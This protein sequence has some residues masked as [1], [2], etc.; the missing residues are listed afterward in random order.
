MTDGASNQAPG[1][2]AGVQ[3]DPRQAADGGFGADGTSQ[4]KD[5]KVGGEEDEEQE[6]ILVQ[7]LW[8]EYED[9]RKFDENYRKQ[10]AIDRRYAA[11]TSDL[12]WAVTTNLIGAFIDI[13]TALLYARD[14]EVSCRKA[15]QV[16]NSNTAQMDSFAKTLEIVITQLWLRGKLKKAAK[17]D[18]RSV[19]STAEGWL[20]CTIISEKKPRPEIETAL[21]DAQET[22]ARLQAQKELLEDPDTSSSEET[23]AL[24]EEKNLLIATLEEKL[25]LAVN[26]MFVIDFLQTQDVQVSTDVSS[27][28][29]HLDADWNSNELYLSKED[30]L[31][32]FPRLEPD[33]LKSAKYYY[34]RAPKEL[35]TRDIDNVLP[36]GMLTAETAQAFTTNQSDPTANAK[37]FLRVVEVWDRRD[38]H[39]RT[40]IDGVT[41]W[42][43]PP[44]PPPYP[45]QRFYPYFYLAFYEVD[46]ARHAQS[47]A[48]RL[49][50][51]QDEYSSVRSNFRITRQRAIPAT[52]F[53]ATGIDEGEARKLQ[54]AKEQEYVAIR[55]TD[56]QT[57][58]SNLFAAKPVSSI[59]P[60]LYDPTYILNDMERI[61]GVQE[62]L[63]SAIASTGNPITATEA[64]IQ[65]SGT[66]ARTNSDR[67]ALEVMLTDLAVY[68]AEQALQCLTL[69]DVQRMAGPKA[70]WPGPSEDGKPGMSI[71]DLF[72]MVEIDI[73]AGS[74]GKPKA[75]TDQQAWAT[76]LP[77]IRELLGQI[78][79]ALATGN[80][81]MA[82]SL[83][84]LI[85]ETMR[86]LGDDSD[87]MRF[88]PLQPPPGTPGAGAP[89]PPV[90]ENINVS[91]KGM[92]DPATSA[93]LV[94]PALRRDALSAPPP[95]APGG[96]GPIPPPGG[97]PIGPPGVAPP[98]GPQPMPNMPVP[99][100][101]QTPI[102]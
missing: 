24:I 19:L 23:D 44:Y 59:D 33:D 84:E 55:P 20:K 21:N 88:I 12:S 45:T 99:G 92:I 6:E 9:A 96:P 86:R 5:G 10:V 79:Q 72:T 35:T 29:D 13:L 42:A 95:V 71:E 74:T 32:R 90:P 39:I 47:L 82:N 77:L 11:G 69:R 43:N 66:A 87:P 36:Q 14:P 91:I 76:I 34:Q 68:T 25:E 7:R 80:Q 51:L 38:M 58:L 17:K 94:A 22:L 85:K 41:K 52:M 60:R 65:Q 61:S 98:G 57:P 53:N 54:E 63:Q 78:E 18:V 27:I 30:V 102:P 97:P 100:P 26:K 62:A 73:K 49:Y 75:P 70:F 40:L 4:V 2:T 15:Q 3:D 93:A 101:H 8:R 46:G 64:N 81:P 31:A 50:K 56:P 16:D 1:G 28:E 48:W 83:I 67:D 89:P 37:P